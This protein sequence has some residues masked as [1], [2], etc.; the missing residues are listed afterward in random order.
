MQRARPST[1]GRRGAAA[2][3]GPGTGGA[4]GPRAR[5]AV[6]ECVRVRA[7]R[8][9]G[10]RGA[11]TSGTVDA[12]I[13]VAQPRCGAPPGTNAGSGQAALVSDAS[14]GETSANAVFQLPLLTSW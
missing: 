5:S 2:R 13:R 4:F 8:S 12:T 10:A 3:H 1:A 7:D 9:W 11:G 14:G 6:R